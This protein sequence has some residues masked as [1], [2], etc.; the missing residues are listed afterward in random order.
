MS[1]AAPSMRRPDLRQ[2]SHQLGAPSRDRVL[3]FVPRWRILL[4]HYQGMLED[5]PATG[6]RVTE[7]DVFTAGSTIPMGT[8][9][10]A[11]DLTR[12][13]HGNTFTLFSFRSRAPVTIRPAEVAQH[14]FPESGLQ[15]IAVVQRHR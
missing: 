5:L 14:T 12:V 6:R 1:F 2:V 11:F 9:P 15:P 4:E 7:V 10:Q 13:E 8:V 3:V